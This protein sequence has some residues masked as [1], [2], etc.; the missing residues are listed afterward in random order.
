MAQFKRVFIIVPLQAYLEMKS[1]VFNRSILL[2]II[3]RNRS[4][5]NE[6]TVVWEKEGGGLFVW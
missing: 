6:V 5:L 3:N 2:R 1:R 4:K